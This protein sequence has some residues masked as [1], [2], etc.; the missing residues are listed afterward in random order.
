[1]VN[2]QSPQERFGTYVNLVRQGNLGYEKDA[3]Q[4]AGQH[5][6]PLQALEEAL[7]IG[8]Q[9]TRKQIV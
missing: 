7:P 2:E 3:R 8:R 4:L 1:M 6:L 9:A 5:G